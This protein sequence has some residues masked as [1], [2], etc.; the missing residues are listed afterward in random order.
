VPGWLTLVIDLDPDGARRTDLLQRLLAADGRINQTLLR[1]GG[2]EAGWLAALS[3]D[4]LKTAKDATADLKGRARALRV[5]A[6]IIATDPASASAAYVSLAVDLQGHSID[7]DDPAVNGAIRAYLGQYVPL[8]G[9]RFIAVSTLL[10]RIAYAGGLTVLSADS[11]DEARQLAMDDPWRR[12]YPG[13]VFLTS[14]GFFQPSLPPAG[15]GTQ[16]SG[17]GSPWPFHWPA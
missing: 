16:R 2:R 8:L 5:D 10:D 15:P 7:H 3:K 13:R 6:D 17:G 11:E 14:S 9:P 1:E 12:I 4:A